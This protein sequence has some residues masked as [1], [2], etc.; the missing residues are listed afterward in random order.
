MNYFRMRGKKGDKHPNADDPPRRRANKRKGHGTYENDR[1]P[2][3][4]IISR[5]SGEV[6]I[7]VVQR[8]SR[9]ELEALIRQH[10]PLGSTI[11]LNTDEWRGYAK[12][13][14]FGFKHATVCHGQGEWARD[15]DQ[16]GIREVHVNTCEGGGTGI[17]N[18]LRL[19]RGVNKKHLAQYCACY[20][21]MFNAKQINNDLL[22]M[23]MK[24]T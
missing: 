9:N 12:V 16:D 20:Q 1:P 4:Q 18:F 21:T 2:V 15:D 24:I 3:V 22:R 5:Q 7:A 17:R 13:G 6:R 10:L 11:Q 23:M 8:T 19:F 14:C